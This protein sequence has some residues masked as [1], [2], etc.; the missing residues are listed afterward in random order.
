VSI[1]PEQFKSRLAEERQRYADARAVVVALMRERGVDRA[2]VL[3]IAGRVFTGKT[4]RRDPPFDRRAR[5]KRYAWDFKTLSLLDPEDEDRQERA[6]ELLHDL[7]DADFPGFDPPP[8]DDLPTL[9]YAFL[10]LCELYGVAYW[11]QLWS[12]EEQEGF[13]SLRELDGLPQA[14]GLTPADAEGEAALGLLAGLAFERVIEQ[15]GGE[16][17]DRREATNWS[18]EKWNPPAIPLFADRKVQT[19]PSLRPGGWSGGRRKSRPF[20]WN[21]RRLHQPRRLAGDALATLIANEVT[22]AGFSLDET[23]AAVKRRM[24]VEEKLRRDALA[25]ACFRAYEQRATFD[26]IGTAIGRGKSTARNLVKAGQALTEA[27][28]PD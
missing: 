6:E 23:I 3:K 8:T 17:F 1:A 13:L 21:K 25:V 20:L 18:R 19:R 14:E 22:K 12:R 11:S 4:W 15:A 26:K 10:T 2:G 7:D 5:L 9:Q 24:T 16:S 27:R 28:P